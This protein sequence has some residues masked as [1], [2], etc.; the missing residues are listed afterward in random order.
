MGGKDAYAELLN[1]PPRLSGSTVS[2][3][4]ATIL[5]H[6][7]EDWRLVWRLL[8]CGSMQIC[9]ILATFSLVLVQVL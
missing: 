6:I 8:K 3:E 5:E 9:V 7:V 4:L 2:S 1:N